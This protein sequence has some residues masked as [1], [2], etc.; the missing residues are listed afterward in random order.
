MINMQLCET[1]H[2]YY[3]YETRLVLYKAYIVYII[4]TICFYV[5]NLYVT[6]LQ[7][8]QMYIYIIYITC[9]FTYKFKTQTF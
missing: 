2:R 6:H 7:N 1:K 8:I 4:S 9:S 3:L 5:T